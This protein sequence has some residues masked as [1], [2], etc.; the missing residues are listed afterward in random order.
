MQA[1]EMLFTRQT[2][3]S[4]LPQKISGQELQTLLKAASAAPV[5]LGKFESVH[6]T[7]VENAELL[8]QITANTE[9]KSGREQYPFYGAQT[10]IFIAA[11]PSARFKE[12]PMANACCIAENILLAATEQ[13]LGSVIMLGFVPELKAKGDL[14]TRLNLPQGMEL[15]IAV[16]VGKIAEPLQERQ[17]TLDKISINYIR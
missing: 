8:A 2:S 13:G 7:V 14:L 5:G 6:L 16:A 10:V 4:F 3:R 1:L 15:Q 11:A 12:I 17:I 9:N